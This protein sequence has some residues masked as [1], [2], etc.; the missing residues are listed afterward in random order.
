MTLTDVQVKDIAIRANDI[1][2]TIVA[3]LAEAKSG[4]TAGSLDMA[5][6]FAT[7]Y[8]HV[9]KHDPKNPEWS[10]RDWLILSNG[11]VAPVQYAAMAHAGYFPVEEC[12]TLRS[13]GS[14]LQGHPERALLPG[15]ETTSGPLG[16]GLSQAA[17]VALALRIDGKQNRVFCAVSDGEYEEGN[18]WEAM[19]CA[20]KYKLN[21]L[22]AIMDRNLIQI[23]GS[24]E[25]VMPLESLV[26]KCRAFNWHV[27]E[28]DGHDIRQIAAACDEAN[29]VVDKPTMILA[30]TIP[31]KGIRSIEGE[32]R[33][34]GK[35]PNEDEATVFLEELRVARASI[36]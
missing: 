20:A 26:D 16:S 17:G 8:V 31:G 25:D 6:I 24:T 13:F 10:E 21:N 4:H 22:T 1:R 15:V 32:Y 12:M 14:R 28:I 2:Q 11:H 23:D 5:D 9:L 18:T 29:T 27:I 19:M 33:W 30:R 7:L 34:H 35:S 3:M 36:V